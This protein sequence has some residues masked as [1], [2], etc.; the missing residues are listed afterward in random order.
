VLDLEEAKTAQAK[1]IASLKKGVKKLEKRRQSRTAWLRRLKKGRKITDLDA[2]DEVTLVDETQ[3]KQDADLIFDAG[4]LDGDEVIVDVTTGEKEE[5]SAK[6]DEMKIN[7]ADPVTTA[8]ATD[9]TAGVETLIEIKATKFK[10]VTIA[11]TTVSTK[12]KAK[13]IP[14]QEPSETTT[15][16]PTPSKVQAKCKGNAKMVEPEKPLKMKDQIALDEELAFKLHAEDKVELER[17]QKEKV[18]QEEAS[19][20]AIFEEID[21]YQAM[22]E[23]DKQSA[24][25][26]QTEEQEK[27]SIDEKSIMLVE[28]IAERKRFF[29][30]QRAAEQIN[31]PP[32]KAHIRNRMCT[33]LRNIEVNSFVPMVV[34]DSK[35]AK[36]VI[37]QES[38][39]KRAANKLEQEKAKKQKIDE[40]V[41]TKEHN[42]QD[43][44]QLKKHME[45]IE[46]EEEIEIEAIPLATKHP[47][48]VEYKIDKEGN[49]RYYKL[50]RADGSTKRYSSMIQMLQNIGREDLETLW[51]L[52]KTK[53]GHTRPEEEYERVLWG[54]LKVMFEPDIESPIW[55]DLQGYKVTVWKLFSSSGV[56]FVRFQNVHIFMLV[57]KKYPL[58]PATITMM[59]DKML[60]V[61]YFTEMCYQLLKLLTKQ[62]KNPGSV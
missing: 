31:K 27:Y 28:M 48:I 57:E 17:M 54:D 24:A 35:K 60:Q 18:A 19:K 7:T 29:A 37:E 23:A 51:K 55:R 22:I 9:T 62:Q 13:G 44:E 15:V 58:T 59:F 12:S 3:G 47:M 42:D 14:I 34:E 10:A 16:V 40:H 26:L 20:A 50:I 36:T 56:H 30:A 33:Y 52:V 25:K 61:D 43:E 1:E 39:T 5:Q 21:S 32:T 41:E 38:S 4:V 11:A 53:H 49:M 6:V 46:D 45:I 2:D 8:S